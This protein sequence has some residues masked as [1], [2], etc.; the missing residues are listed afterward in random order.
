MASTPPSKRS[1][2]DLG[3]LRV[4]APGE[5]LDA[6][7]FTVQRVL[8]QGASGAVYQAYDRVREALVA[9][10]VL[11]RVD[12]AAL[13]RFKAE[14]RTLVGLSHPNLLQLHE[15]VSNAEQWLLTMELVEGGDFLSY[16]RGQAPTEALAAMASDPANDS[17]ATEDFGLVE[18]PFDPRAASAP[19]SS[20]PASSAPVAIAPACGVFDE[21]R[22]RESLR[23]L[24]QGLRALHR[25][26][27]VHR[28]LKPA[29]VLVFE[30]SGRVVICDFGLALQTPEGSSSTETSEIAGTLVYMSPEQA[31]GLAIN[32]ATDWYAVGVMLYQA[33]TGIT[34]FSA[35]LSHR[36][37]IA[38]KV[39]RTPAHPSTL[40]PAAP[41]DLAELAM[42]LLLPVPA[43][44]PGYREVMQSLGKD[45]EASG[46]AKT[47]SFR[48]RRAQRLTGRD[49]EFAALEAVLER[50]RSS[51]AR[52]VFVAGQSGMGKSALVSAFLEA[53][54]QRD[55][56]ILAGRCYEREQLPY[57]AFDPLMDALSSHLLKLDPD[58]VQGALPPGTE[59]LRR[60]FP[61]LDRVPALRDFVPDARV[62]NAFDPRREAFAA[63]RELLRK[64]SASKPVVLYVDDLQW[65]DMDSAPLFLE[66]LREPDAPAV[67]MLCAYRSEEQEHSPLLRLLEGDYLRDGGVAAPERVE[68]SQLTEAQSVGLAL[69]LLPSVPD[70]EAIAAQIGKEARGSPFFVGELAAYV[71]AMG[72][73]AAMGITLEAVIRA[74]IS[75]LPEEQHRLLSL[76]AVAARPEPLELIFRN[77]AL[78]SSALGALSALEAQCLVRTTGPLPTDRVEVYHDNI[79]DAAYRMLSEEA[80]QSTHRRLAEAIE[81]ASGEPEPLF[82]H[83]YA[84][85]DRARAA[86]YAILAA[87]SAERSLAYDRTAELYESALELV[88]ASDPRRQELQEQLGNALMG[89]GHGARAARVFFAAVPGAAVERA[90]ELRRL[91]I[92]QLVRAGLIDAAFAELAKAEHLIG[93]SVPTTN[94]RAVLML[95]WRKTAASLACKRFQFRSGPVEP[96]LSARM[97]TLWAIGSALACVDPLRGGVYSM[98]LVRLALA[99]GD[100][101]HLACGLSQ[102]S[103]MVASKSTGRGQMEWLVERCLEAAGRSGEPHAL[104]VMTGTVG[105]SR[106]LQGRFAEAVRMTRLSWE[107]LQRQRSATVAWDRVTMV[108]FELI[109]LAVLGDVKQLIERVPEAARAADARGDR[110]ASTLFRSFRCSWAHLGIDDPDQ[111]RAQLERA[112]K[113]WR[114]SD[115]SLPS[116]YLTHGLGEIALYSGEGVEGALARVEREWKASFFLRQIQ[117]VR[118]DLLWLQA[119]LV[120]RLPDSAQQ[121]ELRELA[122]KNARALEREGVAWSLAHGRLVEAALLRAVD[123]A[124]ALELLREAASLAEALDMKLQSAVARALIARLQSAPGDRAPEELVYAEIRGYGVK[125]PQ[126]FVNVL[127]PGFEAPA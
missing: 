3:T 15:L 22:L 87:A 92:A 45:A 80:R 105:V 91:G 111:A 66:L 78:G 28:D 9:V 116:F 73:Q 54:E 5:L 1:R 76:V 61:V 58:V 69:S 34:P 43:F 20:A 112:D 4:A 93:I 97:S 124:R 49:A 114:H 21:R 7:R 74:R 106:M 24:C 53:A 36:E 32:E 85:G 51:G 67:L 19:A 86:E 102:W 70:A 60:L 100:A 98:E 16:V 82:R 123:P 101:Y 40:A 122:R 13:F 42:A 63:L 96:A 99:T 56:L 55:C 94:T 68:V 39:L 109:A 125:C 41:R 77:A 127:A 64:L 62:S 17:G 46:P 126:R 10:K 79:R 2:A 115:Y 6:H 35:T 25:A 75:A 37:A 31:M 81:Q 104:S 71:R 121:A 47:P 29:N 118:I 50:V 18:R 89:A 38:A 110:L 90:G 27:R 33:L 65:G 26:G 113:D 57:K 12:P 108:F 84:A 59:A 95:A 52:L 83:W 14:F 119:R 30:A 44:R 88:A 103:T 8:G 48:P 107:L 23:Q 120:L 72:N 11:S 117:S